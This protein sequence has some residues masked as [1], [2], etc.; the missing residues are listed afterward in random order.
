MR[1]IRD[2]EDLLK[3]IQEHLKLTLNVKIRAINAEKND[4]FSIAQIEADDDHY[5]YGQLLEL[6]NNAFVL[7]AIPSAI[8]VK[9]NRNSYMVEPE[10]LVEVAID[11]PKRPGNYEKSLRYTRALTE[12]M[13]DFE[14]LANEAEGLAMTQMI[15]M[16]VTLTGRQL[17][18]SG[19]SFTVAI[20]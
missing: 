18:V 9:T 17:L 6:P 2:T 3:A 11:N 4:S 19:V 16:E 12:V 10:F 20:S 8:P 13:L 5:V 14:P 1:R 15:P 7:I